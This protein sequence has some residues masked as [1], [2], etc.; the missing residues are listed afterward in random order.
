[1]STLRYTINT[2]GAQHYNVV[3][4]KTAELSSYQGPECDPLEFLSWGVKN[5]PR[6]TCK[7]TFWNVK[8]PWTST[9]GLLPP[10]Y[11]PC[12]CSLTWDDLEEQNLGRSEAKW[13]RAT[14]NLASFRKVALQCGIL[15][16]CSESTNHL[17]LLNTILEASI[18]RRKMLNS[19]WCALTTKFIY[20]NSKDLFFLFWKNLEKL[21]TKSF[22]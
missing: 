1:M 20:I 14:P 9:K 19:M 8:R 18:F 7:A 15:Q 16:L 13:A 3:T 10:G 5:S 2:D 17:G 6:V 22:N 12:I 11:K 4:W 21:A